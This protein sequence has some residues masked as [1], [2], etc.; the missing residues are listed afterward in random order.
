M[1][2]ADGS[3]LPKPRIPKTLG[4]LNIIFGVLMLLFGCCVVSFMFVWPT[5][6]EVAQKGIKDQRAM[7]QAKQDARLKDLDE[8]Q[9]A[10]KTEEE[11][12]VIQQEKEAEIA[13][14]PKI[15]EPDFGSID[16]MM[17]DPT[18]KTF[19]LILYGT[20]AILSLLLLIAGIG[21]V[22]RTSWG[23]SLTLAWAA[24]QLLQ[25]ILV[26][27]YD[28]IV[29]SPIQ[30]VQAEKM[31]AKM[32]DDVKAGKAAPGTAESMRLAGSMGGSVALRMGLWVLVGSI[33]PI[34]VL[35]LLNLAGARAACLPKATPDF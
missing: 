2:K 21:L 35:I 29:I 34:I 17:T 31:L 13:A 33:Y 32:E 6:S 10:A 15:A 30:H 23:R 4:I 22:R 26:T 25:L 14:T 24:I 12:K 16:N 20:G 7:I 9:K 8:R 1:A 27:S 11:K 28:G 19:T 3:V 18:I 5:I